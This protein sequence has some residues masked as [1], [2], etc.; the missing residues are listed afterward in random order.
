MP[1]IPREAGFGRLSLIGSVYS[2]RRVFRTFPQ[3]RVFQGDA[4]CNR[5]NCYIRTSQG[6]AAANQYE[7]PLGW[8]GL[9]PLVANLCEKLNDV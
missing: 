4:L 2:G 5:S 8:N 6:G 1:V 9:L 7:L 3:A